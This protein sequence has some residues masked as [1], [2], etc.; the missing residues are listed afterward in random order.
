M[1]AWTGATVTVAVVGATCITDNGSWVALDPIFAFC[2]W[3]WAGSGSFV[4]PFEMKGAIA[5]Q[6]AEGVGALTVAPTCTIVSEIF[7]VPLPLFAGEAL[8][9][10]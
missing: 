6:L 9:S 2:G 8:F 5:G 7:A 3:V 4:V 10:A 1:L